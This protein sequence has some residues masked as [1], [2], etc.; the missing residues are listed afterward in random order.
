MFKAANGHRQGKTKIAVVLTDGKSNN[1][2]VRHVYAIIM[3]VS[4]LNDDM[5][6]QLP[7]L[8]VI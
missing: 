7:R 3:Y 2:T 8:N 6:K 5:H 4:M 1:K